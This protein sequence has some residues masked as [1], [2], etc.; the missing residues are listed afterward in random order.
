MRGLGL[1]YTG[2]VA[3]EAVK[4]RQSSEEE[5]SIRKQLAQQ[6][7]QQGMLPSPTVAP[8]PTTELPG[9]GFK[10]KLTAPSKRKVS[11][12]V[13][14]TSRAG[15][16]KALKVSRQQ[17]PAGGN[18]H[19]ASPPPP[20]RSPSVASQPR[21]GSTPLAKIATARSKI[22]KLQ[23]KSPAAR[24]RLAEIT[25][26]PPNKGAGA[27]P[28]TTQAQAQVEL[29]R[30]ITPVM[31]PPSSLFQSPTASPAP[32][33][34]LNPGGFR[35]YGSFSEA[36]PTAPGTNLGGF[37]SYEL[38][39][40]DGASAPVVEVK[41]ESFDAAISPLAAVSPISGSFS[42]GMPVAGY[43]AL[44]ASSPV[45]GGVG[46]S[47]PPP[48]KPKTLKL[49]LGGPKKPSV[50]GSGGGGGAGSPQ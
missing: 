13:S 41:R 40:A 12:D 16:P 34:A 50:D 43:G 26:R 19:A 18:V 10:L 49:K 44:S 22:L 7:Q 9:G 42:T 39:P 17:T 47:M 37:R 29:H 31:Q 45:E 2:P 14:D 15:S 27:P 28:P 48:P 23:V 46:T 1:S 32:A 6:Q 24:S 25:A 5:V 33:L 4:R 38:P 3:P 8:T 21:R 20:K 30:S 11:V 36:S 35:S